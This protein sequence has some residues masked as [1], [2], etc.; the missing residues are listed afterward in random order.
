MLGSSAYWPLVSGGKEGGQLINNVRQKNGRRRGQK[1][2]VYMGRGPAPP[3]SRVSPARP[4]SNHFYS[5]KRF[6]N[7]TWQYRSG[8]F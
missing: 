7:H 8:A 6:I 3:F 5:C 2:R 4:E 1:W